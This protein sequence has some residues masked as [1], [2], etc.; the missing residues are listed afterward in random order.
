MEN[1]IEIFRAG[2]YP[3]GDFSEADLDQIVRNYDPGVLEAPAVIGHPKN[4]APAYGWVEQ[5]KRVGNTLLAKFRQVAPEFAEA[6]KAGRYKKRSVRL[7]RDRVTGWY[8]KNVGWLG[9]KLP[10][11]K[12][13]ADIEF[14]TA[15][16]DIVVEFQ[17]KPSPEGGE[18]MTREE[19]EA[20]LAEEREALQAEFA[21]KEKTLREEI[22]AELKAE[23]K[24]EPG[25]DFSEK[26]SDLEK[27]NRALQAEIHR[28]DIAGKIDALVTAGRVTPGMRDMGLVEFCMGLDGDDT[29]VEFAEGK[30]QKPLDFMLDLLAALPTQ[31]EF[32]E[33]AT[34]KNAPEHGLSGD[35]KKVV[36]FAEKNDMTYRDALIELNRRGEISLEE[37]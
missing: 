36:E 28:N 19:L 25:T 22:K 8:L 5:L 37:D 34:K 24:A 26:L 11:V 29:E 3:Q 4:T 20:K 13:L 2:K 16:S 10:Q 9:G 18:S 14:E 23:L 17:E 33:V 30:K 35:D 7:G 12:G 31:V 32:E 1:W 21:E 15:D 6:V 27:Q